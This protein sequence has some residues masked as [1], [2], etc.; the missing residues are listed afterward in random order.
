MAKQT[1]ELTQDSLD[2]DV[3]NAYELAKTEDTVKSKFAEVYDELEVTGGKPGAEYY[4]VVYSNT[5][6]VEKLTVSI[7]EDA[8]ELF[9]NPEFTKEFTITSNLGTVKE[10]LERVWKYED[11]EDDKLINGKVFPNMQLETFKTGLTESI[12]ANYANQ[13]KVNDVEL[14]FH[15][16]KLNVL[17]VCAVENMNNDYLLSRCTDSA[18]DIA[19][20]GITVTNQTT[21]VEFANKVAEKFK[22]SY[23][24]FFAPAKL[25]APDNLPESITLTVADVLRKKVS[26]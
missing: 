5:D 15:G 13:L 10:A 23:L 2:L 7:K 24:V 22:D 16:V 17:Q 14:T 6:G 9:D 26:A 3:V 11:E 1:L 4:D 12:S 8:K 18:E 20:H 21:L 25:H 19:N